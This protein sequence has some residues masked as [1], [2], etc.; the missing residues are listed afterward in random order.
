MARYEVSDELWVRI[1]RCCR[2]ELDAHAGH[3]G[4]LWTIGP[5]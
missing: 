3:V 4:C 5:A 1:S 2:S